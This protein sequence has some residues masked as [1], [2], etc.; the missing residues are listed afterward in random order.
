MLKNTL[1]VPCIRF[2]P[3]P[4]SVIYSPWKHVNVTIIFYMYLI[5][6]L[7]KIPLSRRRELH[8]L[9]KCD[10]HLIHVSYLSTLTLNM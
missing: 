2:F 10:Y 7:Y 8:Y 1:C 5:Y 4:A 3:P 6:L 9:C